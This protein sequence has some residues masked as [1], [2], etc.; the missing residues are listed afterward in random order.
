MML[1]CKY[2]LIII[3]LQRYINKQ[4]GGI[5]LLGLTKKQTEILDK[6]RK[7]DPY[8]MAL[9]CNTAEV[10]SLVQERE[11]EEKKKLI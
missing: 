2:I 7:L 5:N 11:K 3:V 10:L 9:L 1:T 6:M 8:K 4:K